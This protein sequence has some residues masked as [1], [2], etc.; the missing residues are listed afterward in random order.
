MFYFDNEQKHSQAESVLGTICYVR[1][2]GVVFM[3][4]DGFIIAD[5]FDFLI[6]ECAK[7]IGT[8]ARPFEL[9]KNDMYMAPYEDVLYRV[10]IERVTVKW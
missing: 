1:S 7:K 2:N 9:S 6:D 5:L 8:G 4:M 3:H 10:N